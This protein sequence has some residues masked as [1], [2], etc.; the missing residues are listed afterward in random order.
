[1][2]FVMDWDLPGRLLSCFRLQTILLICL[3]LPPDVTCCLQR[4]VDSLATTSTIFFL[5]FTLTTAV[6]LTTPAS[7]YDILCCTYPREMKR[8]LSNLVSIPLFAAV[9]APLACFVCCTSAHVQSNLVSDR[10]ARQ[11]YRKLAYAER[12]NKLLG[13]RVARISYDLC[14]P[15]PL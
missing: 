5:H 14:A 8:I 11:P 15:L 4:K 2:Y 3:I 1:M 12:D 6:K 10:R 13:R 9:C 7:R